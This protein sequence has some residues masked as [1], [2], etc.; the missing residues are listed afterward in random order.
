MK[1][2]WFGKETNRNPSQISTKKTK[3]KIQTS[4]WSHNKLHEVVVLKWSAIIFK[5]LYQLFWIVQR[6]NYW[7]E[8]GKLKMNWTNHQKKQKE[9]EILTYQLLPVTITTLYCQIYTSLREN[10][11]ERSI[12]PMTTTTRFKHNVRRERE[13]KCSAI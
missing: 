3:R 2:C 1:I 13:L 10:C 6:P 8:F 5:Q 12:R 9:V 11:T 4:K 7:N